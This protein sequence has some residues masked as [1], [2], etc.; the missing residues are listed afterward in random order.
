MNRNQLARITGDDP[1]AI[2]SFEALFRAVQG[3]GVSNV[4]SDYT[5][6][7]KESPATIIAVPSS[8]SSLIVTLP[9]ESNTSPGDRFR[10]VRA[11]DSALLGDVIFAAGAW[12]DVSINGSASVSTSS[13]YGYIEVLWAGNGL[14]VITANV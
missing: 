13:A 7:S 6:T 11:T 8:A 5:I 3:A 1:E 4:S 14:W 12:P 9:S 2:R 10:V